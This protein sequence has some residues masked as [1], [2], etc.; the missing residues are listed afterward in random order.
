M[1][2]E[3]KELIDIEMTLEIL[4]KLPDY[5][6]TK[7]KIEYNQRDV[8]FGVLCSIMYPIKRTNKKII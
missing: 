1:K 8:L 6:V 4:E 2:I 5:R 3:I 7:E